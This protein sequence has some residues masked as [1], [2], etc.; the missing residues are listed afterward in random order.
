[1]TD[2]TLAVRQVGPHVGWHIFDDVLATLDDV[3][4]A[5]TTYLLRRAD[6]LFELELRGLPYNAPEAQATLARTRLDN[7][8]AALDAALTD[9]GYNTDVAAQ[10]K[11]RAWF[12]AFPYARD[13]DV[14]LAGTFRTIDGTP[15]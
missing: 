15:C 4:A 13:L 12:L 14:G 5:T 7:A 8:E 10:R 9:A 1:M 2:T 3:T 11:N 6:Y